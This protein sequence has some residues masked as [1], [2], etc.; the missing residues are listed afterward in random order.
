MS[1]THANLLR[2]GDQKLSRKMLKWMLQGVVTIRK[3]RVYF[4]LMAM[5]NMNDTNALIKI[6]IM[7]IN[8][9]FQVSTN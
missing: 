8:L 4:I 3:V 5:T 7:L 9:F 1:G 2:N 6:L